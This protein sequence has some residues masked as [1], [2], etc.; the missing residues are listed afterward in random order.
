MSEKSITGYP[1]IDDI[2]NGIRPQSQPNTAAVFCLDCEAPALDSCI[3]WHQLKGFTPPIEGEER[4]EINCAQCSAN[5][6]D[7]I[8]SW[9][10]GVRVVTI[11]EINCGPNPALPVGTKSGAFTAHCH[12]GRPWISFGGSHGH[13]F[14][15][16]EDYVAL[17]RERNGE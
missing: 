14:H 11:T 4:R 12:D 17:V 8:E 16:P 10:M 6:L 2:L 7:L 13:T 15:K 9:P 1:V 3:R 5:H